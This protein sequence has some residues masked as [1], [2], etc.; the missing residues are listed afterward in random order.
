MTG[1]CL[2]QL[3]ATS[4]LS[5]IW[6]F[7]S[8]WDCS[9]VSQLWLK[10]GTRTCA[11]GQRFPGLERGYPNEAGQWTYLR[12]EAIRWYAT[13][14]RRFSYYQGLGCTYR[15]ADTGRTSLLS[16]NHQT[17]N[18]RLQ[19]LDTN[20]DA[21]LTAIASDPGSSATVVASFAD[22]AV[23][24][25]DRRLEEEDAIVRSYTDHSSWVQNVCWHPKFGAQILSAR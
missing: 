9:A 6:L 5:L 11:D 16:S 15:D 23:K 8:W 14:G 13:C 18:G 4:I 25:F 12:L 24:V 1:S 21:P 22:G 19:D 10:L 17:T 3:F 7:D 20:S 2:C